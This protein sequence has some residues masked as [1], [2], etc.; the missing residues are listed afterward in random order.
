MLHGR[1]ADASDM[2]RLAEVLA[3][4]DL[5]YLAPQASSRSWYPYSFLAPIDRN[6][7]FLS[8]AMGMLDRLLDGVTSE[9]VKLDHVML[10]GFSQGAA[11]AS[12]TRRG[13]HD[14]TAA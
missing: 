8:S 7:P 5:A 14:A 3:R 6:E 9:G 13:T 11:W 12:N 10:L 2:L 4:P 1:G